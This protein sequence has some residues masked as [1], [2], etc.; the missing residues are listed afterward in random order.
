MNTAIHIGTVQDKGSV[1]AVADAIIRI[2][3]T[4][5]SP[6]TIRAALRTFR[7]MAKVDSVTLN[8][9]TVTGDTTHYHYPAEPE[10]VTG[11]EG[12]LPWAA[13]RTSPFDVDQIFAVADP[14][15]GI[16]VEVPSET[17][18]SDTTADPA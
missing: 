8:G 9:A 14:A 16:V 7:Y 15:E 12:E 1:D 10:E 13:V 18:K 17:A 6:K 11:G 4:R 5:A 2:L 3:D